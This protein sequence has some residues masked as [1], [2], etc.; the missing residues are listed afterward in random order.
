MPAPVRRFGFRDDLRQESWYLTLEP[1]DATAGTAAFALVHNYSHDCEAWAGTWRMDGEATVLET[2]TRTHSVL[3]RSSSP[4]AS[5]VRMSVVPLREE[6]GA[7]E[8]SCLPTAGLAGALGESSRPPFEGT[9]TLRR[10][11]EGS[12]T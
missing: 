1:P 7:V 6:A 11:G 8:L 12:T 5:G 10:Y 4:E 3:R 9:L 2:T